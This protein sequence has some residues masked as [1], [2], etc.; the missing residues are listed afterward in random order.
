MKVSEG[1]GQKRAL[2]GGN[3]S[4]SYQNAG[5]ETYRRSA[6]I[7]ELTDQFLPLQQNLMPHSVQMSRAS[8]AIKQLDP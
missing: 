4:D 7:T 8:F 3:G 6:E 1:V 5:G 2:H